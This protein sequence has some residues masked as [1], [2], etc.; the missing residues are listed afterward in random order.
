MGETDT[1]LQQIDEVI[2]VIEGRLKEL[3]GEKEEL[4]LYQE[5]D[6]DRR[7]VESTIYQKELTAANEKLSLLDKSKSSAGQW[8][9]TP[10][11]SPESSAADCF[12]CSPIA[13]V[14][15]VSV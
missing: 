4:K 11:L 10:T 3:E 15:R 13:L 2:S 7:V 1:R 12:V 6:T 14:G 8:R 9:D 5:L